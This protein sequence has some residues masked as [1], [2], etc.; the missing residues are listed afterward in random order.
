MSGVSCCWTSCLSWTSSCDG[1]GLVL[2]KGEVLVLLVALMACSVRVRA[3]WRGD[4]GLEWM[5]L[6]SV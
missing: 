6:E 1:G 4:D 3:R 5:G 2:K